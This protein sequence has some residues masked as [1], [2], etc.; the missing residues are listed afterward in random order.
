MLHENKMLHEK[1]IHA[2]HNFGISEYLMHVD[3]QL[4]ENIYLSEFLKQK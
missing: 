2:N 3:I 1:E 4:T